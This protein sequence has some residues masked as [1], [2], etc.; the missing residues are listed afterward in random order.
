MPCRRYQQMAVVIWITIQDYDAFIRSPE[1]E[2]LVVIL[3]VLEVMADEAACFPAGFCFVFSRGE[4]FFV[5]TLYIL[6]SP[7]RPQVLMFHN[8][9][10]VSQFA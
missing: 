5:Q 6:N 10:P 8:S 4:R 9:F 7:R 2:I 1:Y 3:R